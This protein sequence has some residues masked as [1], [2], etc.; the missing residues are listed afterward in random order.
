MARPP[1]RLVL[2]HGSSASTRAPCGPA[3]ARAA[4]PLSPPSHPPAAP[5][6]A[7]ALVVEASRRL[8][9]LVGVATAEVEGTK[10]TE[11]SCCTMLRNML[12]I[13]RTLEGEHES[14]EVEE[15]EPDSSDVGEGGARTRPRRPRLCEP[16]APGRFAGLHRWCSAREPLWSGPRSA[17]PASDWIPLQGA[18]W[19]AT[20]LLLLLAPGYLRSLTPLLLLQPAH[21]GTWPNGF[22]FSTA[23]GS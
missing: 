8:L 17:L 7:G 14:C 5:A 18:L 11:G 23:G 20:H 9:P 19:L 3:C 2:D 13:P 10:R 4:L 15:D 6:P 1:P 21:Q 12:S 22:V 16:A